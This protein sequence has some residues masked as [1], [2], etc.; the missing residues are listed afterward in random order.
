MAVK[1]V[2]NSGKIIALVEEAGEAWLRE[3]ANEVAS[4]AKDTCSFTDDGGQLR[5]SYRPD[6]RQK[7]ARVGTPLESGY[8]EEFGTGEHAV[9]EPHRTG[10]WVYKDGYQGRGGKVLTEDEAKAIAERDP[11][12]HATNGREPNYTLENAF[13]ARKPKMQPNLQKKL[14]ERLGK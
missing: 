4:K 1:F 7:E 11:T 3:E 5:G 12:I 13:N 2:D 9:R 10:W 6:I 14:N 8:W